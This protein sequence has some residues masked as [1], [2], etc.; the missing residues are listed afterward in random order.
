MKLNNGHST[1]LKLSK[2]HIIIHKTLFSSPLCRFYESLSNI[3]IIYLIFL[4]I[5]RLSI[6]IFVVFVRIF[7]IPSYDQV[8]G[9]HNTL[10]IYSKV[11]TMCTV[12]KKNN[13]AKKIMPLNW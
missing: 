12:I 7:D 10:H 8:K 2:I 5:N 6:K 3:K 9:A 13:K 11:F 4:K 1:K